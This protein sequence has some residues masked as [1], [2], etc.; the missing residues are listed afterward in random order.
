MNSCLLKVFHDRPHQYVFTISCS[1]NVQFCG[2]TEVF[3]HQ[4]RFVRCQIGFPQVA[5]ELLL[6]GKYLHAAPA[7]NIGWTNQH[8]EADVFNRR[9]QVI[10]AGTRSTPR[11]AKTVPFCKGLE[12]FSVTGFVNGIAGRAHDAQVKTLEG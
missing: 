12:T 11:H 8:G 4:Q 5:V 6:I 1:V 9:T 3:I 7:Q 10:C 2:V